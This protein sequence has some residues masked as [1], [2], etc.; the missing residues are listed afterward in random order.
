MKSFWVPLGYLLSYLGCSECLN[1]REEQTEK[2]I[3][4][5]TELNTWC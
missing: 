2:S 5:C 1:S 4:K 3:I